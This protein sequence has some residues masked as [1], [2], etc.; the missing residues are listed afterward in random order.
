MTIM[1][2][3]NYISIKLKKKA[4]RNKPGP[5]NCLSFENTIIVNHF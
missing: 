1:L 5:C 3:V 4:L 2:Y